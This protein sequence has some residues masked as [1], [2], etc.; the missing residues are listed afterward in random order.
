MRGLRGSEL[1]GRIGRR[2][3]KARSLD[4]HTR[5]HSDTRENKV[6]ASLSLGAARTFIMTPRLPPREAGIV[7]TPAR[8][9]ELEARRNERWM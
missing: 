9:K 4:A 2:D 6:I 3:G 1:S 8:K 5:R 7:L